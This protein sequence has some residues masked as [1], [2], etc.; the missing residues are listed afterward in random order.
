MKQTWQQL[1]HLVV[2]KP[3][4]VGVLAVVMV[5]L[6]LLC[7]KLKSTLSIKLLSKPFQQ[8]L[9]GKGKQ[10]ASQLFWWQLQH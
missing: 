2:A 1:L 4:V 7:R 10:Q 9:T 5:V 8:L 3:V 6:F